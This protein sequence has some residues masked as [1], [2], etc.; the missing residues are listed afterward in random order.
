MLYSLVVLTVP[1]VVGTRLRDSIRVNWG[2][3][4]NESAREKL[5]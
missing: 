5:F 4:D 2:R 1:G 3:L